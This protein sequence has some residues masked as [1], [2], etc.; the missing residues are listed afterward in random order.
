MP[1]LPENNFF[2]DL[3]NMPH[4]DLIFYCSPNNPTGATSTKDQLQLL[5]DYAKKNNSI[6]IFDAAYSEYIKDKNLPK[7]IYEIEGSKEVAIELNSFSKPIGFTGVR[8]G[9]TVIP[10]EL[11]FEDG[12][13]VNKDWNRI[14]TTI[15]NGASNISQRGGLAALDDEGIVEM[16]KTVSF[17]MENAAIIKTAMLDL[18]YKVYGGDNAPY[19]WVKMKDKKSWNAFDDILE[20]AH[21]ITT[22]GIGFGNSGE[23][24]LR[25]SAFG[26]REDINEAVKRFKKF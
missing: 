10:D 6:I 8:L 11:K 15:F 16:K 1:C 2:P 21:I 23:Y 7:S 13:N 9:W 17:Y 14:M 18:G 19:L 12:Y 24:F 4:V 20:K 3:N 22:P 5:V 25:F 26:S